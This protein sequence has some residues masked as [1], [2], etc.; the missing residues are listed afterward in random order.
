MA[1]YLMAIHEQLPC[2]RKVEL[3]QVGWSNVSRKPK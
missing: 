2:I 3:R 1:Y